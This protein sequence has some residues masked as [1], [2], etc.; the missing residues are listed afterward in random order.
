MATNQPY[1]LQDIQDRINTLVNNDGDTPS[2]TDDE[3]STRLNLIYQAIGKWEMSDVDWDELWT[4]HT[5]SDPV[6]NG[7][8]TYT[9]TVTDMRRLGGFLTLT[10]NGS[11]STVQI[12]SPEQSQKY[13][14]QNQRVAWLTGNNKDGW[15]LNLGWTPAAGDNTVGATMAFPYYKYAYRPTA[16]SDK[17]EMSDPNFIVYDV[18]ATKALLESKNNLYSVYSTEALNVMDRMRAMNE[19]Q[20]HYQDNSFEDV[21]AISFGAVIGE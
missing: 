16:T 10:L 12:I 20:P 19:L 18:A 13:Q 7:V 6:A 21:D 9:L 3:W 8:T 1:T 11:T 2:N 17:V 15:T 5:L 14:G 4:S